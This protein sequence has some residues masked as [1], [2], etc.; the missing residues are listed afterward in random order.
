MGV[1]IDGTVALVTG[2]N[3]GIGRAITEKLLERGAKKVYATARDWAR[4][5][6]LY[7]Q[8][9]VWNGERLLPEGWAD[10]VRTPTASSD[11]Q[12]GAQVW[13]NGEGET[14]P[15]FFPSLPEEMY[16]FSG[17]EGQY[18]FIVPDKR[19]VVVRAGM[20]RGEN[21]MEAVAPLLTAI[22]DAVGAPER[23]EDGERAP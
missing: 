11:N 19:M 15:R 18:V 21:A 10:Y 13:L 14:R 20:T 5:G 22:Y 23:E 4:L 16:F 7:L 2:A 12:Y 6:Q 9:G 3:R 8:D 1:K 17:H